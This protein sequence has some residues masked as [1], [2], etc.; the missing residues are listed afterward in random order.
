M[1]IIDAKGIPLWNRATFEE[2]RAGG[3]TAVNL[4][5]S[6]WEDFDA[7]MRSMAR[8]KQCVRDNGDLAYIVRTADDFDAPEN[9][10]R[11]GIILGWQ[12]ASGFDDYLPFVDVCAELGLRI[13]QPAFLTANSAGSGCYE[14]VDRGLTDFG[15]ELVARLNRCGI[16]IDIAHLGRETARQVVR[17]SSKP[18]FYAQSAPRAL[19]D[20]VRNKSDADMRLVAEHGG[21][22][23]VAALPHYLPSGTESTVEDMGRAIAYVID[24]VGE[25]AVAIG[26]DLTPDQPPAFYQY[27][28]H[29]KGSG[30]R[31][32][33]YSVAPTL[34]GMQRFSDYPRL[35][36]VLERAGHAAG[37]IEK[38]MGGNLQRYFG[39][40][41]TAA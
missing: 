6:I 41:W 9:L 29:D 21:V 4:V 25:D 37:R 23:A 35:I 28:S 7:S 26:S 32:I 15:G 19:K 33:D 36:Q 13:V 34:P 22:V 30:R 40:A 12:N 20:N 3:L 24:V 8:L 5:C 2:M 38:I 16:A 10:N 14:S 1:H 31:L 39:Q 17:A 11:T 18:V 27:V